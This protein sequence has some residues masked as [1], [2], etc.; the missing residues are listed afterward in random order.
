MIINE[1]EI[2]ASAIK[3]VKKVWGV[4]YWI[5]NT[6]LYAM[7]YLKVFPGYQCSIHAHAAKDETFV[8]ISGTLRLLIHKRD[9]ETAREHAIHPGVTY[10][11]RP[12]TFHSF[13]AYNETWVM[14]ISTHAD[15]ADVIRLQ[16]SRKV[17]IK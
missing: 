12:E 5:V 2:A 4:E 1:P 13:Q 17:E 16:E 3:T 14:E 8:G 15:D 7:K 9:M 11:V 10:R 6:E